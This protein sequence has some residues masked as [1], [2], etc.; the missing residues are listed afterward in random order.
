M[1]ILSDLGGYLA[2]AGGVLVAA[3]AWW[4]ERQRSRR[5]QD[6]TIRLQG[7]RRNAEERARAWEHVA[8]VPPVERD[9]VID[10]LKRGDG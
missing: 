9:E 5:L 4:G 10:R 2:A 7:E 8:R 1:G 6:E 3:L